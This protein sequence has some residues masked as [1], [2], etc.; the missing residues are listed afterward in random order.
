[1]DLKVSKQEEH[2]LKAKRLLKVIDTARDVGGDDY[3]IQE[4]AAELR[5]MFDLSLEDFWMTDVGA[6]VIEA[7]VKLR[8][9]ILGSLDNMKFLIESEVEDIVSGTN[10]EIAAYMKAE[11]D[12]SDSKQI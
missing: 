6:H 8:D 9:H 12:T 10:R 7:R 5:S 2:R 4:L 1:M 11:H 3:A